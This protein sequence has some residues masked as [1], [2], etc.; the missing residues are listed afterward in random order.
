MNTARDFRI[1]GYTLTKLAPLHPLPRSPIVDREDFILDRCW[2]KRVL[3]LG[4]AA[5]PD[6]AELFDSGL[7][8]HQ[9]LE[10]VCAELMGIDISQEGISL[11][12][13]RGV[14]N[15]F[16]ADASKLGDLID[17]LGW[18]PELIVAGEIIE[19]MDAPGPLLREHARHI[20]S[21][22]TF[23]ITVPNAFSIKGLLHVMLGHEKVNT[24]HVSYYSYATMTRLLTRFGFEVVDTRCYKA[25]S[26][27]C[28]ALTLTA[29][30]RTTCC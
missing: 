19:H 2:S 16:I 17:S 4:C 13:S 23:L 5:W 24:D 21:D 26:D 12:Q 18:T 10:K 27:T 30:C 7:L 25:R 1:G 8:V 22:C 28:C 11:L 14:R 29:R 6:T 9:K 3:H 15:L 20:P